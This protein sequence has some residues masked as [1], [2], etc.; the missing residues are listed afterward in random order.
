MNSFA[1][2]IIIEE[3]FIEILLFLIDYLITI[4]VNILKY[5]RV[6]KLNVVEEVRIK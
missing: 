4:E 2:F 5:T 6:K 3:K 1:N